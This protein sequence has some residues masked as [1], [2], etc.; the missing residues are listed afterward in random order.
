MYYNLTSEQMD[1]IRE[2]SCRFNVPWTPE[3]KM[4]VCALFR[5]G[6]R[7]EEIAR[8][9]ERTVNAIRIKLLQAGEIESYLSRR[10]KP[11]TEQETDRLG[12]LYSQGYSIAECARLSGRLK[13][14]VVNRLIEIGLLDASFLTVNGQ[15]DDYP[16]AHKPWTDE[17]RR[18][19]RDELSGFR[20]ALSALVAVAEA[21][22]RSIASIAARALS[23][24]LC[25]VEESA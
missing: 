10:D 23:E 9:Q 15:Y 5:D 2:E 13:R 18:Q 7:I 4:E 24:G 3:E 6:K 20:T 21:H 19:L 17:E 11:W 14:E 12:R 22:G 1:R 25:R 16:N 8:L